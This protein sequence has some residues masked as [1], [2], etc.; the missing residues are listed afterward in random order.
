V[1]ATYRLDGE[2]SS[3]AAWLDE[4]LL[5]PVGGN[6]IALAWRTDSSAIELTIEADFTLEECDSE[7]ERIAAVLAFML[8]CNI[9]VLRR[10][11]KP[12]PER[13]VGSFSSV[14][15]VV[16]NESIARERERAA[17]LI[18]CT[19]PRELPGW[20]TYMLALATS[21]RIARFILLWAVLDLLVEAN[22]VA[23]VDSFLAA[24]PHRLPR[25]FPDRDGNE[26]RETFPTFCRQLLAHAFGRRAHLNDSLTADC[27]VAG[28]DL[29]KVLGVEF[30]ARLRGV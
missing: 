28:K 10:H 18:A 30:E 14:R 17:G 7:A 3:A 23:Q 15:H 21:D 20:S 5:V 24:A 8:S 4:V 11:P 25:D 27:C 6:G 22:T 26:K 12:P 19:D 2:C 9:A 1:Q 13:V 16:T 29:E